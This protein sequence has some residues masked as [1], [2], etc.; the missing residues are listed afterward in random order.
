MVKTPYYDKLVAIKLSGDVEDVLL[1][2]VDQP[3]VIKATGGPGGPGGSGGSGGRGG[4]GGSGNPGGQ[5]GGGGQGGKGGVGG[6]G[7]S[8]DFVFDARYPELANSIHLDVSGG[9]AG[10]A[11]EAGHADGRKWESRHHTARQHATRLERSGWQ[12]RTGRRFGQPWPEGA[13]R[14]RAGARRQGRGP[15]RGTSGNHAA[16]RRSGGRRGRTTSG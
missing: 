2:P 1:A 11:G 4:S 14:A 16:R 15:V 7:G 10:E 5:G 9:E 3:I 12:R 6:P 13:R 8:I